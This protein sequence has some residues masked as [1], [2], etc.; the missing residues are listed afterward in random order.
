MVIK[1]IGLDVPPENS[2]AGLRRDIV[3]LE[4]FASYT[5]ILDKFAKMTGRLLFSFEPFTAAFS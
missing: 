2:L 4:E 3:R 1:T 5:I